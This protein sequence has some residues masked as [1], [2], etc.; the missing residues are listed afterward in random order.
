M[1]LTIGMAVVAEVRTKSATS[2]TDSHDPVMAMENGRYYVFC[3]GMG[4]DMLSS[5]DS[6]KTWHRKAAPLDPTPQWVCEYVPAYKGH[7]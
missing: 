3:I 7:T 5:D 4:I 2:S 6:M 1:A